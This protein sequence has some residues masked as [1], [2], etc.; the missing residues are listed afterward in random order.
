MILEGNLWGFELYG[1][2]S[3]TDDSLNEIGLF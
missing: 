1:Q 3:E 2:I